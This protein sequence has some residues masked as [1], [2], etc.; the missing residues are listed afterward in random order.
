MKYIPKC[1]KFLTILLLINLVPWQINGEHTWATR[2]YGVLNPYSLAGT[3]ISSY[4]DALP[5]FRDTIMKSYDRDT[6]NAN[7]FFYQSVLYL[8]VFTLQAMHHGNE[9]F[10]DQENKALQIFQTG[11]DFD[12]IL[13]QEERI[14][15]LKE[16]LTP[17]GKDIKYAL[18][19][20]FAEDC[21]YG[22]LLQFIAVV[23]KVAT[24]KKSPVITM[25]HI[26]T[27]YRYIRLGKPDKENLLKR[28]YYNAGQFLGIYQSIKVTA[29]HEAAHALVLLYKDCQ[30]QLYEATIDKD[31]KFLGRVTTIPL[32]EYL[33]VE[34]L[35]NIYKNRIMWSLAGGVVEQIYG[36]APQQFS[37]KMFDDFD[38]LDTYFEQSSLKKDVSNIVEDLA[39]IQKNCYPDFDQKSW[40][41]QGR[42]IAL[43]AY[44]ETYQ[45]I[46]D[47]K[48]DVEKIADYLL[49]KG[50]VSGDELYE[51]LGIEKPLFD[52]EKS[53]LVT[54]EEQ[55]AK[56]AA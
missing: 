45:F 50:T 23:K 38:I 3:D 9:Y 8:A 11:G 20:R 53:T 36:F 52:F 43:E 47:H 21:S 26:K 22:Q 5:E 54:L 56:P 33:D 30:Y 1:N 7:K 29:L 15:F 32:S 48:Q 12:T 10:W 6:A 34:L 27:A 18:I 14:N 42:K 28:F 13:S 35:E 37:T 16:Q 39:Y 46:N 40:S 41:M 55:G 4:T 51:L 25:E 19:D 17:A 31:K 2:L 24:D 44:Q 49:K